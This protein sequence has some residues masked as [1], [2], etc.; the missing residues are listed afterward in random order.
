MTGTRKLMLG[1]GTII[2]T[3]LVLAAA[4]PANG[5]CGPLAEI[6]RLPGPT[7]GGIQLTDISVIAAD[8]I[9]AVGYIWTA[10]ERRTLAVHYDG[11]S[12]TVTPTPNPGKDSGVSAGLNAI[13][14][15]ASNDI[16]AAGDVQVNADGP[17][18]TLV[19]H[20]DGAT[21]QIVPS[22]GVSTVTELGYSF[23][24]IEVVSAKD[25]WFT[26]TRGDRT[27]GAYT[28]HWDGKSFGVYS[29]PNVANRPAEI[30]GMSAL[31]PDDI[32]GVGGATSINS[33]GFVMRWNGAEW[34]S[35][36]LTET[37][38]AP[39]YYFYDVAA[40]TPDD[41]WVVG[42]ETDHSKFPATRPHFLHWDGA[43]WTQVSAPGY[44]LKLK[45][46]ASDDIY[47]IGGA[48]LMHWDGQ[49][50]SVLST[51]EPQGDLGDLVSLDGLDGCQLYAAGQVDGGFGQFDG[52]I[53][54]TG[55][56][57][58]GDM[59]CD[60][61]VDNFDIDPFVLAVTDET[62]YTATF[63]RCR[64]GSADVNGDGVVNNFDID[65]FIALL[66]AH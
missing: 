36:L 25:I 56:A 40:V 50:W 32:W 4:P 6:E 12:W 43:N 30:V 29:T 47:G 58:V 26:G 59:N 66:T 65:P 23:S 63:P 61:V 7:D 28:A 51:L 27:L 41:V 9:W 20:W 13:A 39:S 52:R 16:W 34:A 15:I 46:F 60:G 48:S 10:G 37:S 18:D 22:P 31:A 19:M 55:A 64:R 17:M 35:M 42:L 11:S 57:T 49:D 14:A 21:W 38:G 24:E 5:S 2:A 1:V 8:D 33:G 54:A 3:A 45:A 53:V 44:A 62:G